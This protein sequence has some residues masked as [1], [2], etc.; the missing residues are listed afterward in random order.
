V[1]AVLDG[2]GSR[3]VTASVDQARRVVVDGVQLTAPSFDRLDWVWAAPTASAG[4]VYAGRGARTEKVSAGWLGGY[5][6]ESLRISREGAR[7]L[8]VASHNGHTSA[9]VSGVVRGPDGAPTSLTVPM[10][11]V[12]DLAGAVDGSWVDARSVVV[13][14][15]RA[16]SPTQQPWLV[17]IGGDISSTLPVQDGQTVTAGSVPYELWVQTPKGVFARS[18]GTFLPV[19]GVRWPAVPG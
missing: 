2:D 9:F 4:F 11:L 5:H 3:L 13:L 1:Y 18:G 15:K 10:Q 14:G 12:P 7:A 8:V 6:V 19:K 16:S 17:Q